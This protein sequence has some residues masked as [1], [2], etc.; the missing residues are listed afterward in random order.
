MAAPW[1]GSA[2]QQLSAAASRAGDVHS[3]LE[4]WK[5]C[6]RPHR[7]HNGSLPGSTSLM[8]RTPDGACW[9]A[10]CNKRSEPHDEM[11]GALITMMGAWRA[12][13]PA[14]T[15]KLNVSVSRDEEN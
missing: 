4:E 1:M 7:W 8:V 2:Y 14:E 9:A 3:H 13:F 11:D 12:A 10:R 6:L 15:W 5:I